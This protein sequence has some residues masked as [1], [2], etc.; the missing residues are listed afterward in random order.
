VAELRLKL[1]ENLPGE[2]VTLAQA[3]GQDVATVQQQQLGGASDA[4]LVTICRQEQRVLVSLDLDFADIRLYRPEQ[5]SGVIVLR[6]QLQSISAILAIMNTALAFAES[7]NPVGQL[8]VVEPGRV[9][10]RT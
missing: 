5:G 2:A 7:H 4:R 10:V 9:R 3:R 1:D 6:P 8:W